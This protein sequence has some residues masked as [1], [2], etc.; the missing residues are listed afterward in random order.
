MLSIKLDQETES[1]LAEI[2][3]QENIILEELLKKLIYQEILLIYP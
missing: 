3:T 2:I 1:Y